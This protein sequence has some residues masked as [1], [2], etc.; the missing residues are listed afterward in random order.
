MVPGY[1]RGYA[2]PALVAA[3]L[4]FPVRGH[5]A[6]TRR[7]TPG[8]AIQAGHV[9]LPMSRSLR[10]R[11]PHSAAVAALRIRCAR[12]LTFT[13]LRVRRHGGKHDR[14]ERQYC[15]SASNTP[16]RLETTSAI[17]AWSDGG[18]TVHCVEIDRYQ[19]CPNQ[20]NL[21]NSFFYLYGSRGLQD[22]R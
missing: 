19:S 21:E 16:L 6:A 10:A 14:E 9:R 2:A 13:S 15:P 18:A 11:R 17:Y 20:D 3:I 22:S 8:N 1:L 12:K 4:L 7:R 5:A